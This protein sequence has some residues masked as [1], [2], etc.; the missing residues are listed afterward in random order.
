[1]PVKSPVKSTYLT[2]IFSQLIEHIFKQLYFRS[3]FL[4]KVDVRRVEVF[5]FLQE[6]VW[7]LKYNFHLSLLETFP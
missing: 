5:G 6:A 1:M 3:T 4:F 2:L 7:F